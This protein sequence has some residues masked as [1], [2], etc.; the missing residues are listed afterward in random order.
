MATA[1]SSNGIV[2][3]G[4]AWFQRKVNLRPVHRGCHLVTDELLKQIPEISQFSV[5]LFHV[6]IMHTSASLALNENWDPHVRADM[7]MFL[8][9]LVPESTPFK[10]SCEG[11]DDMPA[12]IKACFLGSSLTIPITDGQLNLGTWQGIWLCEHRNRAGSRKVIVTING[13]LQE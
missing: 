9:Q 8:T 11:P 10:H 2:K 6:Q 13:A 5:G 3:Q 4:S 7:E 12:H 1:G